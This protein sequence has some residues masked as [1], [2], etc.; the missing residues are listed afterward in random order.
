MAEMGK[1]CKAYQLKDLRAFP[2]WRVDL[3]ALS[4]DESRGRDGE[5]DR[6]AL[7]DDDVL[8]LQED[9]V[10]TDGIFKDEHVVFSDVSDQ[11]K[12]FCRETLGFEVP[13]WERK[14]DAGVPDAR[15][16]DGSPA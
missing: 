15:P 12:T 3:S 9:L 11:W 6:S 14:G 8:Y 7:D 16:A 2:Q 1:Y 5:G 10:V 4:A 13:T